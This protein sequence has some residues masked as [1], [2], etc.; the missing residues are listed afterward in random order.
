M[1]FAANNPPTVELGV[2][3]YRLTGENGIFGLPRKI[4]YE[5]YEKLDFG[6]FPTGP[7]KN[8]DPLVTRKF[9]LTL[10]R[11]QLN[12]RSSNGEPIDM[13]EENKKLGLPIYRLVGCCLQD[14][15][16]RCT[17][18]GSPICPL[19]IRNQ[20]I[21]ALES[22]YHVT[23]INPLQYIPPLIETNRAASQNTSIAFVG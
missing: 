18:S 15:P 9:P 5:Y 17:L 11:F 22:L 14:H 10:E 23:T 4:L 3:R 19:M 1:F 2:Q 13:S 6:C 8:E 20:Q 7:E 21:E 16:E 12:A